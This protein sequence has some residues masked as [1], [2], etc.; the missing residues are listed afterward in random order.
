MKFGAR[1]KKT[2]VVVGNCTG[3][4]VNRVFFPYNQ[5]ACLLVVGHRRPSLDR[6]PSPALLTAGAE[7]D[8]TLHLVELHL[9]HVWLR[10]P[11]RAEP[12]S[13]HYCQ[14]LTGMAAGRRLANGH[15]GFAPGPAYDISMW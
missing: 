14:P 10:H 15:E 4:A 2:C 11:C 6:P 7:S 12:V 13:T 8:R 5:A 1:I 9:W 3:F